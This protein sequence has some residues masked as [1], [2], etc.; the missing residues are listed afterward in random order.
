MKWITKLNDTTPVLRIIVMHSPL[1]P[2]PH[3]GSQSKSH[4]HIYPLLCVDSIQV[5]SPTLPRATA[6]ST[7][8]HDAEA[9]VTLHDRMFTVCR[10]KDR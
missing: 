8:S 5:I 9:A 6:T 2:S 1:P 3:V 7:V 4:D 10:K